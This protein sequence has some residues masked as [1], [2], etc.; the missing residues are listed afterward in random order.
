MS[1]R[2]RPSHVGSDGQGARLTPRDRI[3]P[4]IIQISLWVSIAAALLRTQR[5]IYPGGPLVT[6]SFATSVA[7]TIMLMISYIFQSA[8][9]DSDAYTVNRYVGPARQVGLLTLFLG[10]LGL[11]GAIPFWLY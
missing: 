1:D 11:Y 2:V 4:G 6:L 5:L 8:F 3:D 7:S 10:I 9:A